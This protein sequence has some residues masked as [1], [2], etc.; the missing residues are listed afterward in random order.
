MC[1]SPICA[2]ILIVIV[3]LS[4][5]LWRYRESC[6]ISQSIST[7]ATSMIYLILWQWWHCCATQ[8]IHIVLAQN[9]QNGLV[10]IYP[11]HAIWAYLL[12][13]FSASWTCV[14]RVHVRHKWIEM[15]GIYTL[16]SDSVLA[17]CI[18]LNHCKWH[19]LLSVTFSIDLNQ[20]KT[21]VR[22]IIMTWNTQSMLLKGK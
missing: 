12:P 8:M 11:H 7:C 9:N 10:G 3:S 20:M 21:V 6:V 15:T 14:I 16:L 18:C 22:T 17:I 13:I 5:V 4:M 2:P 19:L 1:A